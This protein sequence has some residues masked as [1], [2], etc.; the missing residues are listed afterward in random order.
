MRK[1]VRARRIGHPRPE[2]LGAK[3]KW[4]SHARSAPRWGSRARGLFATQIDGVK[5]EFALVG[6]TIRVVFGSVE[7]RTIA[8]YGF[9]EPP[10]VLHLMRIDNTYRFAAR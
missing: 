7:G 6:R 5:F 3:P 10:V 4:K 1:G 9:V 2:H 8:V